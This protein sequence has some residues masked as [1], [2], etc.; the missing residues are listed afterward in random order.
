MD[1][2]LWNYATKSDVKNATDV[3]TLEFA[4]KTDLAH[5]KSDVDELD[6]DKLRN[7]RSGLSSLKS[8][9]DKLDVGKI[10]TTL[11][12]LSKLSDVVKNL[13]C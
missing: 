9:V 11:I 12:D 10:E 6:I 7:V 4:K 1:L 13:C 3:D 8:I 2:D 5:L